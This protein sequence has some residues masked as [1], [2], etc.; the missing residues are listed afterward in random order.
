MG[1]R[2]DF[3]MLRCALPGVEAVTAESRHR[4][5]RHTHDT[6]GIGLVRAGAQRSL[7]GRG[8]VEAFAGD[9]IT[10]NPGEV[11][12]GAPI[13][14]AG[15][16]WTMLYFR[17]DALAD[18][19][20][21]ID[22]RPVGSFEL[23]APVLRAPR[24]AQRFAALFAEATAPLPTTLAGEEKLLALLA[25]LLAPGRS[26]TTGP[27]GVPSAVR[28]ARAR[29]DD[30]PEVLVTLAALASEAGLS[31]FQFLRVFAE[32][33]GLT[34]HAYLL[35]R[36][37]DRARHLIARGTPLAA[38]AIDAGFTDQSHLTRHFVAR[39]GVSPGSYRKAFA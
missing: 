17:P 37:L 18:V 39:Y 31:R 29:I 28:H 30:R 20:S 32:A 11:H 34:P 24:V 35:Q 7:S 36:R 8:T 2:G 22:G 3:R 33:T 27:N 21:G 10:V 19:L 4:F 9:I 26:P 14:D 23:T 5:P 13:G 1:R 25:D 15:R 38:A 16:R 12:D 6:Y